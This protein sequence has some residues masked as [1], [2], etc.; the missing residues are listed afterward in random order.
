MSWPPPLSARPAAEATA[1][2]LAGPA[3]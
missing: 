2:S 1:A 3:P